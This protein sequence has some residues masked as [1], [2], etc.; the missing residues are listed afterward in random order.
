[1]KSTRSKYWGR[2]YVLGE[3]ENGFEQFVC[4]IGGPAPK[5]LTLQ[6]KEFDRETIILSRQRFAR[7]LK[8]H[9]KEKHG[10]IEEK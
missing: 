8:K 2:L 10:K 1:M 7:L 6:I 3:N 5:L 9:R 4:S